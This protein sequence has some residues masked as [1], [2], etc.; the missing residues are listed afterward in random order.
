MC[1]NDEYDEFRRKSRKKTYI[2]FSREREKGPRKG[3]ESI[4]VKITH[5]NHSDADS[6]NSSNQL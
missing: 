6:L 2:S 1:R 5:R 3:K 4:E